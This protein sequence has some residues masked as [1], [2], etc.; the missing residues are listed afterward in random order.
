MSLGGSTEIRWVGHGTFQFRM[1]GGEV[2]LLDPWLE[3]NPSC[4]PAD[5]NP[6]R[7]DVI[8]VTHGHGD[9]VGDVVRLAKQH[10]AKVVC[11]YDICTW[12]IKHGVESS[13][14]IGMNKGGSTEVIP[15]FSLTMVR[16]EHSSGIDDG[17]GTLVYM[18]EP[19]GYILRFAGTPTIYASG[20]TAVFMDMQ[21]FGEMYRP[22]AAILPIGGFFTMDPPAAARA[23]RMLGV[24]SV[25]PGHYG[26]FP[27]LAGTPAELQQALGSD[28]S[29][30]AVKPG[31]T[32]A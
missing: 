2:V 13:Q 32:I 21:L 29:V 5:K 18:G 14:L 19:V 31:A 28:V 20:D 27:L 6:G 7:V 12:L 3:G 16:A 23:A 30:L 11:I 8:L 9:H 1:P 25:I 26:T 17:N 4:T 15:G 10:R 22:H 24:K